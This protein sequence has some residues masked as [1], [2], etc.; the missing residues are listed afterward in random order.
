MKDD[1]Y[2]EVREA[3]RSIQGAKGRRK[4]KLANRALQRELNGK[5]L[6]ARKLADAHE[7]RVFPSDVR[8]DG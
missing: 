4:R 6:A 7:R 8:D 5:G 3:R 2:R 1:P